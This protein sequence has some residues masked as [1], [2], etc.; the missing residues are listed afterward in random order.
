[1]AD[2]HK[3]LRRF[4]YLLRSTERKREK[5][6][7]TSISQWGK[8]IYEVTSVYPYFHVI[9]YDFKKEMMA[10]KIKEKSHEIKVILEFR[11]ESRENLTPLA[12]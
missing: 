5:V 6:F 9:L 1:M 2:H 4:G 7:D 3:V 11:C 12:L 10:Q 8:I